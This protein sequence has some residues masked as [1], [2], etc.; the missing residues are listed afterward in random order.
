MIR[1]LCVSILKKRK[2]LSETKKKSFFFSFLI[3]SLFFGS[4]KRGAGLHGARPITDIFVLVEHEA[5]RAGL[6]VLDWALAHEVH[7]AVVLV[8]MQAHLE[9]MAMSECGRSL[10]CQIY[11]SA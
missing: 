4:Y 5:V 8:S 10:K 6:V 2:F 9:S 7:G 11:V 1:F 3:V